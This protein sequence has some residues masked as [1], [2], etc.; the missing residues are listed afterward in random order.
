MFIQEPLMR[1]NYNGASFLKAFMFYFTFEEFIKSI[2]N[3]INENNSI[4]HVS[5]S[6][7]EKYY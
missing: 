5:T 2:F 3:F 1:K 4:E 6:I 7:A